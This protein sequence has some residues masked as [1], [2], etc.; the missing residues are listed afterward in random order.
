MDYLDLFF[1]QNP[2]QIKPGTRRYLAKQGLAIKPFI[3]RELLT[4]AINWLERDEIITIT[5]PR[6]A[7]KTTILLKLIEHLIKDKK[8][9]ASSIYYFNFDQEELQEEFKKPQSLFSFIKSRGQYKRYWLFLDEVQRL[10]EAGLY[11]K[12]LYDL[13]HKPFKMVVSGSSS[14]SLRAKTKEHLTGRQIEFKLLPLSFQEAANQYGFQLPAGN[15]NQLQDLLRQFSV[16]G[17]YPNPFQE[18][19]LQIKQKLLVQLYRDYVKK[20]IRDFAG[21]EKVVVFNKLTSLLSYQIG[22]LINKDEL[23]A[24][25][26]ADVRTIN[27]YLEILEQTFL[28]KLLKPYFTNRR[29]E[30]S[31]SPKVFYLDNGLCNAQLNTFIPYDKRPDKGPLFENLVLTELIKHLPTNTQIRYWRTQAGAEVDFVLVMGK[32]LIPIEAKTTLKR[33]QINQGLRSFIT[34]YQPKK[35]FIVSENLIGKRKCQKTTVQFLPFSRLLE[36]LD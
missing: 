17:G 24:Q 12:I 5:G 23:A 22:N 18:D 2:W 29:K 33:T 19:N 36:I 28:I 11:L 16:Y 20:D 30:I 26:Q 14:L 13:P 32:K 4:E 10:K 27:K 34:H 35:A 9:T 3:K 15:S 1:A 21:V 6:Q 8:Q 7:G 31:K 25:C